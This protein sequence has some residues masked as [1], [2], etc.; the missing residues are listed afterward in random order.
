MIIEGDGTLC[1]RLLLIANSVTVWWAWWYRGRPA[2]RHWPHGVAVAAWV[3]V[4]VA[5][6]LQGGWLWAVTAILVPAACGTVCAVLFRGRRCSVR[7]RIDP[8]GR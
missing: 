3:A 4:L 6:A 7:R 1:W 8:Q 5:S 2:G